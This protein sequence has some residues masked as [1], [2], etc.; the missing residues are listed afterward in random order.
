ML[1][2]VGCR[3]PTAV[4]S[5]CRVTLSLLLASLVPAVNSVSFGANMQILLAI[6]IELAFN[7]HYGEGEPGDCI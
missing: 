6:G 4:A 3:Y 1:A 2:L 5:T 7:Q